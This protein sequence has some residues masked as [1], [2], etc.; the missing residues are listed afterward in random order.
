MLVILYTNPSFCE[1]ACF[2]PPP[3]QGQLLDIDKRRS[4]YYNRCRQMRTV[5]LNKRPF[6]RWGIGRG[7]CLTL[8][9]L[10]TIFSVFFLFA[11]PV[12]A[13]LSISSFPAPLPQG[14]V[15]KP[16]TTSTLTVAGGTG[17]YV[18]V[19]TGLPTGL[20]F[21]VSGDTTS[22]TI[23]GTPTAAGTFPFS[24]TV[25]D[26]ATS[27][28]ISFA[29]P[30][31]IAQPPLRFLTTSLYPAKEGEGYTDTIR[32]S[33][34][35]T[36]YTWSIVSGTLPTRL[37]LN[38]STG[39]ISGVPAKGTA[40]S[41]SFIVNVTDSSSPPI[42]G[43]QGFSVTV[44]KG[45]YEATIT[46]GNGLKVG[47]TKVYVAGS[48]LATLRGGESAKLSLDIGISRSVSVDPVVQHPTDS[49]VRFKAEVDRITVS[50]AS[51]DATFP[52]YTE[53][54]I[55]LKTEP[56]KV[57]QLSGT[58][59]YK[60]G[61]TLRASAPN[62][63]NDPNDPGIQYRFTY[64]KLPTGET[65]VGRELSLTVNASG[66]CLA[67]YDTYYRL[68]L[69]SPYGEA[70]GSDW[71]KAG[72]T[73]EWSMTNPQVRMPGILGVFGGKLNAGNSTGTTPIDG[74]KTITIDWEPDYTMPFI[75]I[76]LTIVLL[77]LGGYGLYL[78]LRSLQPKP[79]LYPPSF[80][81]PYQYM[82]P[83]PPQPIPPP[84]TTVVMIGGDKPQLGP[85]TTKDQLMEKFGELLQKYEDEIKS[86]ISAK[87]LPEAKTVEHEKRLPAPEQTPPAVVEAE[88]TPGEEGTTCSFSSKRPLRIVASN[89]RQ[90]ETRTTTL[91][92][93]GKKA[94][95]GTT[96]LAITWARDIYQ[97]W[98]ILTC[99]LPRG[100]KE[101]HE[102]SVEIAY[103]QLNT[104]TEEKIYTPGQE[105][106]PPAPHYT[107]GMPRVEVA[108]NEVVPPDK[109]P[110]ETT[111]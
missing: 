60:E 29:N 31:T 46:I 57:G 74:P 16:Y 25:T 80:P 59:W 48:P 52:Y 102:G 56:S 1:T 37:T 86:T 98:E 4:D 87:E 66:T 109:L 54:S 18:W 104:I 81:P 12:Q 43:Q 71:Y 7:L 72:S 75:M 38:A 70:E 89:W 5:R 105:L 15:G 88:V 2:L 24:V 93:A 49:A 10:L 39:Y 3:S 69:T 32:V 33:G 76:P 53:Y 68:T 77:I 36:P 50:E 58:G 6:F 100:H 94:A 85:P 9:C 65:V 101:P 106:E 99:W 95:E 35:T 83:P 107:D 92:S 55:E 110:P 64:W 90:L 61:Y 91:P 79:V 73:A 17:P 41:Y 96:G 8:I 28:I 30:I 22:A 67:Y 19:P 27:T 111:S 108:A 51:P 47:E 78:L 23:S 63:V 40:G 34:G 21:T 97:E 84:Q 11:S 26:T 62:E 13:A 14:E 45:G 20:I 103:S 44:E 42:T 82:P